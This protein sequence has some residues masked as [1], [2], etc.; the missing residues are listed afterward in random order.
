M[1]LQREI[2]PERANN[3]AAFQDITSN[4]E[5]TVLTCP[6]HSRD[7]DARGEAYH[8]RVGHCGGIEWRSFREVTIGS[9]PCSPT[10]VHNWNI[11]SIFD[12]GRERCSTAASAAGSQRRV[13]RTVSFNGEGD[14]RLTSADV[15][16]I[17][18]LVSAGGLGS[19]QFIG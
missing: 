19:N 15:I 2:E 4:V 11:P 18:E 6:N 16:P 14:I 3:A 5:H 1:A 8:F 7:H 10:G 12:V 9:I 17:S 13:R